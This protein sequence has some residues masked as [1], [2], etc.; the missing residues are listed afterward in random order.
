MAKN[1]N[2]PIKDNPL[3][4]PQINLARSTA[5]RF[6]LVS[7]CAF[8]AIIQSSLSDS[9]SSLFIALGAVT[10]ALFT[11]SLIYYLQGKDWK[12]I[13]DG[14]AV[15]TALILTIFLPNL[16]SPVYA[17]AGAAFAVAVIKHSFGG[18]GSN[19][20]NP[21]V[22]GWS[23][24][25]FSWPNTFNK[26]L[27]ASPVFHNEFAY[28]IS[29]PNYDSIHL[30]LNRTVFMLTSAEL[31]FGYLDLF[32]SRFPGIIA[33]R[34]IIAILVGTIIITAF[35]ANRSWIPAAYLAFFAIIVRL[36]GAL[37][38]GL[39]TGD[40]LFALLSGGTLAAAFFLAADPVTGAKSN[41][42]LL[43]S[44][45]AAATLAFLFR[46]LGEEPYGAVIAFACI[47]S[48]LPLVKI[49]ESNKL[50]PASSFFIPFEKNK[51]TKAR[52]KRL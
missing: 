4:T 36:A 33:D 24:I 6:W 41:I 23:F 2:I 16:I 13:K 29:A 3:Q 31:P 40:I 37:P 5:T 8:L 42:G 14:S 19:W 48:L 47:N 12:K 32:N 22:G 46:Y 25:R 1:I 11:E 49:L 7:L 9:F 34:G 27:E 43:I 52:K 51:N 18:L 50:Y 38:D 21:A 26:A 15:S 10:S 20:L 39:W 28:P 35:R 30:F 44:T 17:A 45:L